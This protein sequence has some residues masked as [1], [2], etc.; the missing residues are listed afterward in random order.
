MTRIRPI[1]LVALALA[2]LLPGM[3]SAQLRR[4]PADAKAGEIRQLQ[5]M[6]VLVADQTTL[7]LA[8]S[9]QIRDAE[10]RIVLPGSLASGTVVLY[11]LDGNGDVRR[12]WIP[13]DAE[14]ARI[15]PRRAPQPYVPVN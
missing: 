14:A 10:N 2:A 1:I 13:G 3:S 9:A 5:D 6:T 7:R 12:A 15:P 4:L 8:V 11:V